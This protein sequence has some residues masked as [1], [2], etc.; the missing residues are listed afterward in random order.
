MDV[1]W[2]RFGLAPDAPLDAP[3]VFGRDHRRVLEI[4]FGNGE[5]LAAMAEADP[6][7]DFIGVEVHRPG[8]GHL[9]MALEQGRLANVRVVCTDAVAWLNQC[10]P[11]ASIDRVQ[12]F[13]PDPWPKKRHHKRR[14]IQPAFV[15]LL[16]ER[17][18]PGGVIHCATDW[19]PYAEHMLHVLSAEPRLRNTAAG[20]GYAV[21]PDYRPLT[22]FERRGFRIGHDSHDL[23]F[24]LD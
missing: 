13:F 24:R 9:L 14:L 19:A 1:L 18:R 16:C 20:N 22:K 12:V 21:K 23:V 15:A 3:A 6:E 4:G 8:V 5:S 17:L 2:P 11:A 7:T 10:V